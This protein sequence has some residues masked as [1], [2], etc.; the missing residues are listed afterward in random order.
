MICFHRPAVCQSATE[1]T[2]RETEGGREGGREGENVA[3]EGN[4]TLLFLSNFPLKAN[5]DS[6]KL[7][8][9]NKKTKQK[10]DNKGVNEE[11]S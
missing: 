1:D 10:T 6:A 3:P 5:K 8:C 7:R 11:A 9:L 4:F 2:Q